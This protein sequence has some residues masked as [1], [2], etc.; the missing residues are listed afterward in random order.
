V[1]AEKRTIIITRDLILQK[2]MRFII[3]SWSCNDHLYIHGNKVLVK[4]L[5]LQDVCSTPIEGDFPPP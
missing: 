1:I 2:R 5:I 3:I 4:N